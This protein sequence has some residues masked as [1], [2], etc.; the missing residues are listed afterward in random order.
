MKA[1]DSHERVDWFA[2]QST[3]HYALDCDVGRQCGYALVDF[4]RVRNEWD[5]SRFILGSVVMSMLKRDDLKDD[6][7]GLLVGFF[8]AL[9]GALMVPDD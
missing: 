3:G 4:L 1:K 7:K 6:A 8:S 5:S 9:S 2:V